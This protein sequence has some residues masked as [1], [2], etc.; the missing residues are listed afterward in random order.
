MTHAPRPLALRLTNRRALRA[1]VRVLCQSAP[2]CLGLTRATPAS[3]P[4]CLKQVGTFNRELNPSETAEVGVVEFPRRFV[5]V[6]APRNSVVEI[7]TL[8][9]FDVEMEIVVNKYCVLQPDEALDDF[10]H[11]KKAVVVTTV[12]YM[13]IQQTHPD[14]VVCLFVDTK[15][16]K[17][18]QLGRLRYSRQ[19]GVEVLIEFVFRLVEADIWRVVGTDDGGEFG[20]STR[21]AEAHEVVV[22]VLRRQGGLPTMS[23]RVE[24]ET[25]ASRCSA[26]GRPL[27]KTA[28][29]TPTSL[30]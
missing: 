6:S 13:M 22:G 26:F 18:N 9:E 30:S 27:C 21:P 23:L 1:S 5:K 28:W 4:R 2:R 16:T 14:G 12:E 24:K 17:D 3:V 11:P 25:S 19:E 29:P 10:R 7:T 15:V 8:F 20:S